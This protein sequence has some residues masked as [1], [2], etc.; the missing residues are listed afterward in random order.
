V[1]LPPG[2]VVQDGQVLSVLDNCSARHPGNCVRARELLHGELVLHN[3]F[4]VQ[5]VAK[6]DAGCEESWRMRTTA[7][8]SSLPLAVSSIGRPPG[9]MTCSPPARPTMVP[10]GVS[11]QVSPASVYQA[12]GPE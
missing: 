6:L 12:S 11:K 8:R 7:R 5:S 2:W 10:A 3:P 1:M 4:G 9:T